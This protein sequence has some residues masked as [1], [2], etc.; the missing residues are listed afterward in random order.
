MKLDDYLV[1]NNLTQKEFAKTTGIHPVNLNKYIKGK[2][3]PNI[4][5]ALKIREATN[6]E[7]DISDLVEEDRASA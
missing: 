6:G 1:K 5:T 3:I 2:K 4:S 7:V